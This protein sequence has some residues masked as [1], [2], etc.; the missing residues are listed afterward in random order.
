MLL[1]EWAYQEGLAVILRHIC[2]CH[3]RSE[4]EVAQQ[5][6]GKN[7]AVQQ[8]GVQR[9]VMFLD[10]DVLL[11]VAIKSLLPSTHSNVSLTISK[12]RQEEVARVCRR[13]GQER[14][15]VRLFLPILDV[16]TVRQ[17]QRMTF[18]VGHFLSG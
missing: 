1:L 11:L 4:V 9:V 6:K 13:C 17:R 7:E 2:T 18:S 16:C 3:S 12:R 15:L 5:L 8:Q 10:G 14:L